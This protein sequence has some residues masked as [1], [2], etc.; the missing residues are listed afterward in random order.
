MSTIVVESSALRIRPTR[1]KELGYAK[2]GREWRI[3]DTETESTVGPRY[4]TKAELLGDLHRYATEYGC[5]S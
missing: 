4:P 1:F 5:L 2:V 3:V